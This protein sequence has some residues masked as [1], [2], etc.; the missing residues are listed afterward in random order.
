MA[1]SPQPDPAMLRWAQRGTT[2]LSAGPAELAVPVRAGDQAMGVLYV[3]RDSAATVSEEESNLLSTL[4][5]HLA[6]ALQKAESVA[7]T[8]RLAAQMATL[9]DLGLQTT[10]LQD[11][12]PLFAKATEEVGR[13]TKADH[14]SV[15]R[16]DP[17]DDVLRFFAAWTRDP[18][19]EAYGRVEFALGE[20]IAGQVARDRV[21][22][23]R[24]HCLP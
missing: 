24:C 22:A 11:L 8:E 23:P 10:A 20:G 4:A 13:L 1:L 9:Y 21:P 19:V 7:K 14:T 17:A 18:A 2:L 6:L 3:R 15:L 5:G 16:L 12:R